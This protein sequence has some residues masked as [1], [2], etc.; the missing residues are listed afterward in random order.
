MIRTNKMNALKLIWNFKPQ[1]VAC[2]SC[3]IIDEVVL[4]PEPEKPR[5]NWQQ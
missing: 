1:F 5:E 4:V 2:P 3:F